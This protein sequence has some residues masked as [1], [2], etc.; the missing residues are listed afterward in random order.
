MR[1][2]PGD[3]GTSESS[4]TVASTLPDPCLQPV[5]QHV[6]RMP[7]ERDAPRQLAPGEP[8]ERISV[9]AS[10]LAPTDDMRA[11]V[12]IQRVGIAAPVVIHAEQRVDRD[13][14]AGLLAR[15]AHRA[16]ARVLILLEKAARDVPVPLERRAL[17]A[18][19]EQL[20]VAL[21][22]H[23]DR[24]LRVAERYPAAVGADRPH[25][26]LDEATDELRA[27]LDAEARANA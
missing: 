26:A 14:Q 9:V 23:A 22:E 10:L 13:A 6:F 19:E 3:A 7:G 24:G 4:T 25:A 27:A 21:D 18:H 15:L 2:A 1:Y 11:V 16:G 5:A 12:E 17:A 20:S 8:L